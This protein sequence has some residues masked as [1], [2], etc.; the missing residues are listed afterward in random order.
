[1]GADFMIL[2]AKPAKTVTIVSFQ[3]YIGGFVVFGWT[4]LRLIH[5]SPWGPCVRCCWFVRVV[6][7]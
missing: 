1:M 2:A 4:T 5:V 3:E 6:V 7:L